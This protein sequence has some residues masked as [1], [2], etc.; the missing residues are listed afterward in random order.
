MFA[1]S[2]AALAVAL[3]FS[4]SPAGAHEGHD[5][6][7]APPA[8]SV[9]AAPAGARAEVVGTAFELVA[10]AEGASLTL[11]LD[12]FATNEPLGGADITVETPTGPVK[13]TEDGD[14]YR[15]DAPFL[16]EPGRFDLIAT[17]AVG[18]ELEILPLT[19][20]TTSAAAP[21]RAAGATASAWLAS[22]WPS[23]PGWALWSVILLAGVGAGLLIGIAAGRRGGRAAALLLALPLAVAWSERAEAHTGHD[24]GDGKTAA[25]PV[26]GER[27][28]R[29]ADGTL[30]VPKAV[31]RIFGVRT[32]LTSQA[33][34]H[35]TMELPG[36]VIPDPNASGV[37]QASVGGRLS[38]PPGGFPRLGAAVTKGDVLAYVAPPIQQI[39]V[40]DM[41]QRQG[42]LDQ[43]ISI[44]E[45]RLARYARLVSSGAVA[46]QMY[47][48]TQLELQGLKDRRTALDFSRRQP[49]ALVA[50]VDGI[51]ADASPVAGQMAQPNA[52]IFHIVDPTRLWVEAL[53]FAA[54][55]P[56]SASA[57]TAAGLNIKLA[58]RGSGFADRSQSI[59]SHFAIEGDTNG[60]RAGQFVTVQVATDE[61]RDGVAVPRSA[62]ARTANGQDFVFEHTAP[63]RFVP[64]PVR[65][66]PLDGGRVL[67]VSGAGAGQ[68]IVTQGADLLDHVR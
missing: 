20:V 28:Q 3:S 49:E 1:R 33:T 40:S 32:V 61:R 25:I 67:I 2:A 51:V 19:L 21:A 18:S 45:T 24:H 27:A 31:Q 5:H 37:V 46:R 4:I 39:D 8:A 12:A 17:V 6:G 63:E 62:V 47:E 10:V 65:V 59:P 50:P 38:A 43:Q 44:V 56:V 13:A 57:T 64:R 22:W 35:R 9:A 55:T 7:A 53:S 11:Y 29:L 54:I 14:R 34:F 58:F 26:A 66:E 15:L 36:R 68:R 30:H 42:E 23:L 60:L 52:V 48:E 16:A 41:R